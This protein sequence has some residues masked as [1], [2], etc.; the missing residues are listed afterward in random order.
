MLIIFAGLPGTGKSTLAR[1]LA[2]HLRATYLG[3]DSVDAGLKASA[4]RIAD[5]KDA[6]Y[7]AAC[8]TAE[9]NLGFGLT[10]ITDSVNPTPQTRR[11]FREVATRAMRP[12]AEVE[13]ICSD[14]AEHRRRVEARAAEISSPRKP[15]W[16]DVTARSYEPWVIPPLR[17]DTA[18]LSPN[19]ALRS[20]I[21]L[22]PPVATSPAIP[23]PSSD[24]DA[25]RLRSLVM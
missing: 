11:A 18:G 7:Q 21:R 20:L 15:N 3:V 24:R 25:R 22:L 4:L 8:R 6:G 17:I 19:A 1:G 9:D 2:A 5:L 13:V 14:I 23:V 10:V 16:E 12:F